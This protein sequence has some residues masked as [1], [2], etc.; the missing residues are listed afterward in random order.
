[1]AFE[2]IPDVSDNAGSNFFSKRFGQRVVDRLNRKCL[3]TLPPNSGSGFIW[4]TE[5]HWML[6]LTKANFG[7]GTG[8][9]THNL[10][11]SD[12]TTGGAALV[13]VRWGEIAGFVADSGM[14]VD[15]DPLFTVTLASNGVRIIYADITGA[16]GTGTSIWTPSACDVAE[17]SA[18][19]SDTS[20]HAY[21]KI[22]QATRESDGSGGYRVASGSIGQTV[23]GSQGFVRNY[24]GT[25][26]YLQH[27]WLI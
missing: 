12:A 1:M 19:P 3:V 21:F 10:Q 14:D 23:S 24:Y 18:L 20:T 4:Q 25:S 16:Y 15:N 11:L 2:Q 5:T 6:D 9:T 17:G 13:G 22:G 26:T 7:S 27:N 8:T